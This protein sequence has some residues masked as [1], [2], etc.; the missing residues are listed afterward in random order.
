MNLVM[1]GDG[2]FVEVQGTAEAQAVLRRA[3]QS[4]DRAW[5]SDAIAELTALQRR[6][7]GRARRRD[8]ASSPPATPASCASTAPCSA[9]SASTCASLADYPARPQVDETGDTYL[10]NARAKA[11]ALAAHCR[12]AGPGGRLRP[13]GRRA[14]RRARRALGALRRRCRPP[15]R[16][17]RGQRGPAARPPAQACPTRAAQRA[18]AAS[19][20]VARPDGRELIAEGTCEGR[21]TT[22]P[23]GQRRLR[24]RPGLPLSAARTHLR[25]AR[26]RRR[27]IGSAIA[28][29]R[30]GALTP[31]AWARISRPTSAPRRAGRYD[32]SLDFSR[33]TL[34]YTPTDAARSG[35]SAAW[36]AHLPWAQG[37]G[38]SNR[39]AP[40]FSTAQRKT[41][42]GQRV[43]SGASS[44]GG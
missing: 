17:R 42:A 22:A 5:R 38:R 4:P 21:I 20:V 23:R 9:S 36:L 14:R 26:P 6:S 1:T 43:S 41:F 30:C 32:I 29:A 18:F 44:S 7:A 39:L 3:A 28:P 11:H 13:R 2:Q 8:P 25:R 10:A 35:R 19:I 34:C 24:L 15:R 40:T 16:R 37:V 33:T 31:A 27:K 12:T